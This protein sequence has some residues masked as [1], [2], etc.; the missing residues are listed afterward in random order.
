MKKP[1][2]IIII[3]MIAGPIPS[4]P[5]LGFSSFFFEKNPFLI[6]GVPI[7]KAIDNTIVKTPPTKTNIY[8][9]LNSSQPFNKEKAVPIIAR[10]AEYIIPLKKYVKISNNFFPPFSQN[11]SL[12]IL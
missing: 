7:N 8:A 4:P 12:D 6:W 1:M 9:P 5:R 3:P 10:I 11:S 2:I